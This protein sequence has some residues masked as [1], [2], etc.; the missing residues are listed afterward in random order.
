MVLLTCRGMVG[1]LKRIEQ[2][3]ARREVERLFALAKDAKQELADR[4]VLLARRMAERNRVSLRAHNREHCR[5]CC[6]YFTGKTLRVRM[7]PG[8]IVY[9]CLRCEH[10]TRIRKKRP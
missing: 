10:V 3:G 2:E 9:T 8:S 4:Y 6:A 7:R 5:K 1:K